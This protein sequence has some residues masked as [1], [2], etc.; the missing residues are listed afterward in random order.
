M[1]KLF[2]IFIL[3]TAL[4]TN[5]NTN[6]YGARL[7][8][9]AI[10]EQIAEMTPEE[11]TAALVSTVAVLGGVIAAI[12]ITESNCYKRNNNRGWF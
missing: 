3:G 10:E 2:F 8:R 1:N 11:R 6:A 12:A 5:Q 9:S 4:C 7:D